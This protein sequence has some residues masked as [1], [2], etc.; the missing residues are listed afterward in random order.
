MVVGAVVAAMGYLLLSQAEVFWQFVVVRWT[1]V[2]VGDGLLGFMVINVMIARWFIRKRG[3]AI[4][5]ASMGIGFAKIIM[6]F[7]LVPLLVWLGWRYTWGLFGVLTVA[8]LVAPALIYVRRSPEDM[9]L[10]PDGLE[11]RPGENVSTERL[12]AEVPSEVRIWSRRAGLRTRAF[13]L[14]VVVFGVSA[15]GVTGV[16][17]HV[18]SYVTDLG[19]TELRAAG[20][21]SVIALTQLSSPLIW[22]LIA[23]RVD[24]RRATLAKF[25]IQAAGLTLAVTSGSLTFLYVGFFFYGVGLGG[26]MVLPDMMWARFFGRLSMGTIRG[27]GL[28]LIHGFAALGPPFFGFLYDWLGS[29]TISLALFALTLVVSGFLSLFI[30]APVRSEAA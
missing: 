22:G 21:M 29:Y 5:I 24:V 18:F 11:S 16:N 6:P 25:L 30:V 13:W 3:R 15:V 7:V 8:L 26:N 10:R 17:L 4:A 27:L 12:Q 14:I 19:F 28:L 23:E 9:G 1:L 2:T 20:V